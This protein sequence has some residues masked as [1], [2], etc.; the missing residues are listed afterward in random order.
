MKRKLLSLFLVF[1][2]TLSL[3]PSAFAAG[4]E[5]SGD[6]SQEGTESVAKIGDQTYTTLKAAFEAAQGE[7]SPGTTITLTSDASLTE[8]VSI[9]KD[10]TLEAGNFTV[11]GSTSNAAVYFEITGGT[12]TVNGGKF[13][14]FGNTADTVTG[15][16]VFKIPATASDASIQA[17]GVTVEAF[18]RAA[19]DVRNGGFALTNCTIN[20][21]NSQENRLNKG[22]VAGYDATGT[23]TGSVTGGEIKGVNST[24]EGWSASGIEIS[25]GATVTVSGVTIDSTKGGISVARNYGHGAATVTVSDCTIN[26]KDFALRI[27]ESNNDVSAVE[28]SSAAVTIDSGSYTGD[29]RISLKDDGTTDGK[30]KISITGGTFSANVAEKGFV[31]DGYLV[32][33]SDEKFVVVPVGDAEAEVTSDSGSV[34]Y[35]TLAEAIQKAEANNAVKLLKDV[36]LTE[37]LT[38]DK[39]IT[40]E[41]NN[42]TITGKADD[43]G[44]YFEI[45]SG[46]FTISD[47]KLTGFGHKAETLTGTGVFKVPESTTDAKIVAK[48]LTV[49]NFNRAAFD[50][51]SGSFELKDCNIN[52]DNG[53]E[54]LLTK[55]IVAWT[56]AVKGTVTGGTI[57][58]S[59]STYEGWSA[60][61][62]EIS[63][64]SEVTVKD[65]TINSTKGGISVARNAGTGAAKV[66]VENCTINAA[67]YA[68]R[69]F[70]SNNK[71]EPVQGSSATVTVNGGKYTG[72][73]RISLKDNG[74]TDGSSTITISEGYF[75]A[76]PTPYLSEGKAAVESTDANY[77][78]MVKDAG[79]EAADVVAGEPSV[80]A[81]LPSDATEKDKELADSLSTAMKNQ[82]SA[83]TFEGG[84]SA[85]ANVV[86]D[87]NTVTVKDGEEALT[88]GGVTVGQDD[89]VS[90]VIQPYMD[91]EITAA[92]ADE[93]T[94]TL[95]ITPMYRTIAT[96]ADVDNGDEIKLEDGTD[97]NAVEVVRAKELTVTK[98][99]TITL[100]LPTGFVDTSVNN[101]YVN[102][103][104]DNGPTYV[105]TG[106]VEN[107]V[108]TFVNPHG[109]SEFSVSKTNSA[110]AEVNGVS[111]ASLQ[112]AV[113]AV[114]N[115]G[116]I[117]LLKDD[118][119]ATVSRKV[120]FSV[121]SDSQYT[122]NITAGSG[123]T[124]TQSGN[125]YTFTEKSGGGGG[126][127]GSVVTQYTLTFDTN[128]GT[129]IAKVTKDKGTKVDLSGY[130]TTRQGYTFAGWYADEALTDKVTSVT[131]N[132]NQ[133]VYAKW[134]EKTPEKPALPF[135]DVTKGDWFYDAVQYVY[136]KGMMNG[137]DGGRFAPNATTSRAMIVTILYRLENEPAVSGKSPFTDV[138]AGQWYTNAVA[139]AAANGIVTGTT[140]TT[141]APNGNIT[142]EQMAA[143]L[144]RYASYKGLDVSRQADL[145]GYADANA[146]SAYAKQAMAWANGQGLITG[147][148]ATTLRPDGNAVRA[149][150]A[151]IL[152]RLCEQVL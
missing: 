49:E 146:I 116:I 22:V 87:Q 20:C 135:T 115:N 110:V 113:N 25:S 114:A 10:V 11:T 144:Y 4:A 75:T 107:N 80:E 55:G 68:L 13:T 35:A 61:G 134:T 99:V 122:V 117:K 123:F 124:M 52:C 84:V 121:T 143:I 152:M 95:D 86:A 92:D 19:F 126:G 31:A 32:K 151:T 34:K 63:A 43:T 53:A 142:R 73:V 12:F 18:N 96:T 15:A 137:V 108:L 67:D 46:T 66:T 51:R 42:K 16:G 100:P 139:W 17:T 76:D 89:N 58:G 2:M 23:V 45:T 77:I 78:F 131:L 85:A 24:Y 28:G 111:Y 130:T 102:H 30:S 128:G 26:A 106:T 71:Y 8:K 62:I 29:V 103:K 21:D 120:S 88:Q 132:S 149:Q 3:V 14:S 27:F 44:V 33:S 50:L 40:L 83:P 90:I 147:V 38:I 109:F 133:T 136:D 54:K 105:Y 64:G 60:N 9:T 138:A 101:L 93:G 39:A 119:S 48:N 148:T 1:C 5:G 7:S 145:S 79:S 125:T 98:S 127:G 47:A 36:T 70:E 6:S 140:D 59:N 57:I 82:D 94:F 41:G 141:F 129:A 150:A 118:C 81:N 97:K 91:I 65:V 74:T 37:K 72:D 69:I 112:D 56:G 104:K